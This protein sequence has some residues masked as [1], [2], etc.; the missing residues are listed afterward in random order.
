MLK[1]IRYSSGKIVTVEKKKAVT[2]RHLLDLVKDGV[3]FEVLD[4][5]THTNMYDEMV[6]RYA[7][8]SLGKNDQILDPDIYGPDKPL[9]DVKFYKCNG[10]KKQ[11]TNRFKCTE[12]WDMVS[13]NYEDELLYML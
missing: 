4:L 12:C 10:C 2:V 7:N 6:R 8:R 1:F 13:D 3:V 11:T 5:K 9:N